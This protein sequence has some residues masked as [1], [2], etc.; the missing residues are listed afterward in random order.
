VS[1]LVDEL[2]AGNRLLKGFGSGSIIIGGF[3]GS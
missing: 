2:R 1:S 3:L